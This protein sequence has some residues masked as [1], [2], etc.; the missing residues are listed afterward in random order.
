MSLSLLHSARTTALLSTVLLF[1]LA[2]LAQVISPTIVSFTPTSGSSGQ[3]P[4]GIAAT[5]VT[6]TGTALSN[7]LSVLLNGQQMRILASPANTATSVSVQ[8]PREA[9]T[10]YLRV[11]TANGTALSA[12]K[13]TV[14]RPA[15]TGFLRLVTNSFNAFDAGTYST[16]A[17]TDLDHDGLIDLL[18]G[19][20]TGTIYR[21]EQASANSSTFTNLGQLKL[22]SGTTLVNDVAG[23]T[24]EYAK[25]VV[26]DMDGDGLLDLL[27]GGED[28]TITRYEQSA[29]NALTFTTI[30]TLPGITAGS[31]VKPS[32]V[33]LDGDGLLDM[34]VGGADGTVRRYEQTTANGA[35][36]TT[37][38]NLTTAGTTATTI[39][40]GGYSKPVFTD[41][42]GDGLIDMI[43]GSQ[44]GYIYQAEQTAANAATF[45]TPVQMTDVNKTAVDVGGFAAPA[46]VDVDG[47]G[48]LD[49]LVGND[50]GTIYQYEQV[51][52]VASPLP[53]QLTSFTAQA[54]TTGT[55]LRWTTAQELNS[56]KF[57]V[58][59]SEN[60][61]S[62]VAVTEVAAAGTSTITRAYQYQDG[63]TLGAAV[64]YYRLRQV[65][66]DG[67]TT[68]SSVVAVAATVSAVTA[69]AP[70]A[71]P[72][73]FTNEL[74]VALPAGSG[75]QAT[76]IALLDLRGQVVYRATLQLSAAAKVLPALPQ[77]PAGLYVLQMTTAAGTTSQRVSC[78]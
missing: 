62:F 45:S 55:L 27:V 74:T 42:D 72:N 16:A 38:T 46:L 14:T 9:I 17:S 26:T 25:P 7:T 24:R 8:V 35:F 77:L 47:D 57:V 73:P 39:D 11:T 65:D 34:L 51:V 6:I 23:A 70:A 78:Q 4:Q 1:P 76:G 20:T 68:Y 18:V 44:D 13:F 12:S 52:S 69:T 56:A 54:A 29:M 63:T 36:S 3:A 19:E 21:L 32:I 40:V 48:Y 75:V 71:Y 15:G 31:T 60:G 49:L 58:E 43:V 30:G 22:A 28:G 50:I 2:S 66:F 5:T 10:G 64:R 53:V 33:D 61:T 37:S 67:T 41:L 59:R